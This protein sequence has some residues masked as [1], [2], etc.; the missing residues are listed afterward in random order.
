MNPLTPSLL[1]LACAFAGSLARGQDPPSPQPPPAE[2]P[3][4]QEPSRLEPSKLDRLRAA[5]AEEFAAALSLY[6][7]EEKATGILFI[8][9]FEPLREFA[10]AAPLL[11]AWAFEAPAG[12]EDPTAFRYASLRALADF[13]R[14]ADPGPSEELLAKLDA[15]AGEL[16]SSLFLRTEAMYT[17][18]HLGR[19]KRIEARLAVCERRSASSDFQ[20][21]L[22]A[23]REI[24]EIHYNLRAYAKAAAA[25]EQVLDL[26]R[27]E[28]I[29]LPAASWPTLYYNAA[30]AH[31]LAGDAE[32]GF[33]RFEQALLAWKRIGSNPRAMLDRDRDIDGL[34]GDPRFARLLDAH[35]PPPRE[36]GGGGPR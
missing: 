7:S 29:E 25:H 18:A 4:P 13:Y 20:V 19:P 26:L 16:D 28:R 27:D 14:D 32:K 22:S 30:C 15:F 35:F 23:L 36:T 11:E 3:A 12:I 17:L 5:K 10:A 1:A 34:R 31:A 8:G 33:P 6:L 2:R 21:R 24:A 9:Q